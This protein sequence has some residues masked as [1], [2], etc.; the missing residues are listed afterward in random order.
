MEKALRVRQEEGIP[1]T[2]LVSGGQARLRRLLVQVNPVE[3]R[4][5]VQIPGVIVGTPPP[6]ANMI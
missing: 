1:V 4:D 2:Q 5:I 3:D 6:P